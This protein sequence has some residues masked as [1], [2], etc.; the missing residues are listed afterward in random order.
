M[1]QCILLECISVLA[2]S[3]Q[4]V[5]EACFDFEV[6]LLRSCSSCENRQQ[7]PRVAVGSFHRNPNQIYLAWSKTTLKVCGRSLAVTTS[8]PQQAKICP[9]TLF[10][11]LAVS[12]IVTSPDACPS[13]NNCKTYGW[14]ICALT[15]IPMELAMSPINPTALLRTSLS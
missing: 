7:L 11:Q 1:T 9:T 6:V 13:C 14:L 8:L 5:D 4:I 12:M 2:R 15:C 3:I 10:A